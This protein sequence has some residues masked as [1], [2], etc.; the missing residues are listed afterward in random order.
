MTC[1]LLKPLISPQLKPLISSFKWPKGFRGVQTLVGPVGSIPFSCSTDS[2]WLRAICFRASNSERSCACP[3]DPNRSS[4]RL[5]SFTIPKFMF[6]KPNITIAY[7]SPN[8][9][10]MNHDES[11][12]ERQVSVGI[13]L[14]H[15]KHPKHAHLG[16]TSPHQQPCPAIF[17]F[18]LSV[19]PGIASL[20]GLE[21]AEIVEI[22]EIS[23]PRW[24]ETPWWRERASVASPASPASSW[25]RWRAPTSPV[26]P[27]APRRSPRSPRMRLVRRRSPV[28]ASQL[29]GPAVS[30][31]DATRSD[32]APDHWRP[33]TVGWSCWEPVQVHR[34]PWPLRWVESRHPADRKLEGFQHSLQP[35]LDRRVWRCASPVPQ[36]SEPSAAIHQR[37]R[38]GIVWTLWPS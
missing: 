21:M 13:G 16:T 8:W 22:A 33:L 32:W 9:S 12:L 11:G 35:R 7:H 29:V 5:G 14:C 17:L 37:T 25:E 38:H 2:L 6:I 31:P 28:A 18:L 1:Q 4:S 10:R 24:S 26:P 30:A 19:K 15:P 36:A 27:V 20:G 3:A 34:L 23:A